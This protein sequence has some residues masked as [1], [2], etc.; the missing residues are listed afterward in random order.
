MELNKIELKKITHDFNILSSRMMRV[1]FD[2]YNMVL[3]KFISF[4][5]NHEIIM[6]YL[7]QGDLGDFDAAKE[8]K[9]VTTSNGHLIFDF[10]PTAEEESFQIYAILRHVLENNLDISRGMSFHYGVNKFQE[11]IKEFNDRVLLVLIQNIEG[12]LT[13]IG[14]EMGMDE[15]TYW[16][17]SGGQV[18]I[19]NNNSTIHASQYN[20]VSLEDVNRLVNNIFDNLSDVTNENKETI[21]D[22]VTMIRDELLKPKPKRAIILNGIKLLSPIVTI[23]GGISVAAENIQKFIEYVKQ[24]IDF[25]T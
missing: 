17:V 12:H 6:D 8:Y 24:F 3:K 23:L 15:N 9:E 25:A 11:V 7:N 21:T 20:G 14:F 19:A 10:G 5:E 16:V 18:N 4:I 2:E 1:R 22:A 13:K